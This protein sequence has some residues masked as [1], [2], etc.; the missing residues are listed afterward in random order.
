[1]NPKRK[2]AQDSILEYID[3]IAA[4]GQNKKLYADMFAKMSDKEFDIYMIKLRDKKLNLSVIVPHDKSVTVS[5]KNNLKVAKELGYNFYQKLKIT[6]PETGDTY[7]TPNRYLVYRLPVKRTSQLLAKG[8]AVPSDTK[9]IDMLTGQVTGSSKSTTM[10][11]PEV[12]MLVGMGMEQVV[13]E[14]L[15]YRGGDLGAKNAL[16]NTLY[17]QGR[18]D[19]DTLEQQ[20]TGVEST[21]TLRNYMLG[22]HLRPTGLT[23]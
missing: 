22:A 12:Q 19:S 9:S 17:K 15:K 23:K 5:V 21:K 1:M 2:K 18:V 16:I 7:L 3:K 6:D 20:S 8:I 10:T 11:M 14:L 4:G 13:V